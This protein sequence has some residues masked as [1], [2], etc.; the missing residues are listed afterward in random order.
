M[1]A[2]GHGLQVFRRSVKADK[3]DSNFHHI[4]IT[5]KSAT[6]IVPPKKVGGT[7]G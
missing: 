5:P 2:N 1:G 6:A 3:S 4:S 7:V